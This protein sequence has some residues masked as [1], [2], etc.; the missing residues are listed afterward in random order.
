MPQSETKGGNVETI[1]DTNIAGCK[2]THINVGIKQKYLTTN[3]LP[4]SLLML[5]VICA[6]LK[7]ELCIALLKW[8][9][10]F[11][12]SF[13]FPSRTVG[14]TAAL[15]RSTEPD[16]SLAKNLGYSREAFSNRTSSPDE[17]AV[18]LQM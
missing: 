3:C 1:T 2:R 18:S 17:R 12:L 11:S 9:T 7:Y 4:A 10:T 8:V 6:M 15:V 16:F 14:E 13:T 5:I